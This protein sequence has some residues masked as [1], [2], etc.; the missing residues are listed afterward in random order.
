MHL[1]DLQ[2]LQEHTAVPL[3]TASN[4]GLSSGLPKAAANWAQAGSVKSLYFTTDSLAGKSV[5]E[6]GVQVP[7]LHLMVAMFFTNNFMLA[8][9]STVSKQGGE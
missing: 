1:P 4:S 5:V 6:V 3:A 7:S 8:N 2:H 9:S